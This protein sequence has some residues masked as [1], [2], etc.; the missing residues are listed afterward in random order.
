MAVTH[1]GFRMLTLPCCRLAAATS[2]HTDLHVNECM[3][4]ER[5]S[6]PDCAWSLSSRHAR[7]VLDAHYLADEWP[8]LNCQ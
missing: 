2:S 3:M 8:C 5:V 7:T 4:Q 6:L 1:D